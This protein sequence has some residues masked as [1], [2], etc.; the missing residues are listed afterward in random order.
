MTRVT[1]RHSDA[2]E[3]Q[4]ASLGSGDIAVAVFNRLN[5]PDDALTVV[6]Y[7]MVSRLVTP[8]DPG[9]AT[10]PHLVTVNDSE[11]G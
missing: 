5:V 3:I 11:D 10:L 1:E 9:L 8:F 2:F 7:C 6:R 4:N